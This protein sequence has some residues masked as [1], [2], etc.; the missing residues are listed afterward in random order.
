MQDANETVEGPVPTHHLLIAGTGRAGTSFL[1]RYLSALGLD[2]GFKPDDKSQAWEAN[3]NAGLERLPLVEPNE[4]LPYVL[5]SPWSGEYIDEI[6]ASNRFSFDAIIIPMR[7]LVEAASSRSILE[8]RHLH[9]HIGW[10][11]DRLDATWEVFAYTPG[12]IIYSLNP[13]DQARLLAIGFHRL[14]HSAAKAG[15]PLIFPVF[16]RMVEDWS[17]LYETLK[18]ILPDTITAEAA[19]SVHDQVASM[20]LVRVGSELGGAEPSQ[21]GEAA[22][23]S[24][25]RYPTTSDIDLIAL[26]RELTRVRQERQAAAEDVARLSNDVARLSAQ[27]NTIEAE[28]KR[29]EIELEAAQKYEEENAIIL[30]RLGN[31]LNSKSW[32]LTAP[33]RKLVDTVRPKRRI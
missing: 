30:G 15:I 27:C 4:N 29:L 7:D 24:I 32:R 23:Q 12:G 1:V 3:A 21:A 31:L 14:V 26:R 17:Y 28:A 9:Q 18:P 20:S 19:K 22:G 8:H 11:A 2:T 5:K 6:L 10:M 25:H 16:P 13:L 33:L